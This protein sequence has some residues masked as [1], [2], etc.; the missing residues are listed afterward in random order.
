MVT[1][2]CHYTPT[3]VNKHQRKY[4]CRLSLPQRVCHTIISTNIFISQSYQDRVT[5]VDFPSQGM[6]I[7]TLAQLAP[8]DAGYYRC[9]IGPRTDML[10]SSMNL[11]I[12][13]GSANLTIP[14]SL[15]PGTALATRSQTMETLETT[16]SVIGRLELDTTLLA[17]RWETRPSRRDTT[18]VAVTQAPG[19]TGATTTVTGGQDLDTAL[20]TE[21]W[22]TRTSGRKNTVAEVTQA[23][24]TSGTT[25]SVIDGQHL[26]TALF[27]ERQE[28]RTSGR[29]NTLTEVTQE[30]GTSGTT[31]VTSGQ[32][33]KT[34]ETTSAPGSQAFD[35]TLVIKG[36]GAEICR[37]HTTPTIITKASE[38]IGIITSVTSRPS[39]GILG[40]TIPASGRQDLDTTLVAKGEEAG[41]IR[42]TLT[43]ARV[44][45]PP[46]HI[47][48]KGI[49][50]PGTIRLIIP[51]TGDWVIKTT[52][53]AEPVP[54]GQTTEAK[55]TLNIME[56]GLVLG[57]RA[58]TKTIVGTIRERRSTIRRTN[59][60]NEAI[61][62][63]GILPFTTRNITGTPRPSI[64]VRE[65]F[66]EII[67][68][69]YQQTWETIRAIALDVDV[70]D[71]FSQTKRKEKISTLGGTTATN[72][73]SHSEEPLRRFPGVALLI[74]PSNESNKE[75]SPPD[76]NRVSQILIIFSTVLLPLVLL[77]L[78]LLQRKLRKRISLRTQEMPMLS[79][80]QLTNFQDL[81]EK[82]SLELRQPQRV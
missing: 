62:N 63:A 15:I 79:L 1:I 25:T 51:G 66:R 78:L 40:G 8:E 71:W 76:Q 48:S 55:G 31:L 22:E 4:W 24:G 67:P 18:P 64:T 47:S 39:P 9:G 46:A 28:A 16:T 6:F 5:L 21:E 45:Q 77:V 58:G 12:S 19:I 82:P 10:F 33:P 56:G 68:G 41:M 59:G 65:N 36:Q 37:G 53:A 2:E 60:L 14:S 38:N 13:T 11:T 74:P 43:L 54:E 49:Q 73:Q 29:K 34:I 52:R 30:P 44:T 20:F 42:G 32:V 35:T 75:N 57:T 72:R 80:I 17:E 50:I 69:T 27:T 70:G 61:V 3:P 7:V 23:P 81:P 26:D